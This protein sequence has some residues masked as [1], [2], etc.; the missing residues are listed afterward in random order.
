MNTYDIRGGA[1]RAA[2][3]LHCGLRAAGIES[4]MLVQSKSS[5]DPYVDGPRSR[6]ET[7]LGVMRPQF[8]ILPTYFYPRRGAV[9]ITRAASWELCEACATDEA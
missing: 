8:D 6:F 3:R 9:C 1:A 5:D 7:L 2:Y 4:Q